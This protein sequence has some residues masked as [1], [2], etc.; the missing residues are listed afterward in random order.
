MHSTTIINRKLLAIHLT[1][2]LVARN[3]MNLIRTSLSSKALVIQNHETRHEANGLKRVHC[4]DPH[5]PGVSGTHFGHQNVTLNSLF[6]NRTY[7]PSEALKSEGHN[8]H[9]SNLSSGLKVSASYNPH[10]LHFLPENS[11]RG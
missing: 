9:S 10:R 2:L 11:V 8:S 7:F 6:L 1:G 4:I 3:G 5:S